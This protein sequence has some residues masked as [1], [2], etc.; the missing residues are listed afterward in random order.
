MCFNVINRFHFVQNV[1]PR[2]ICVLDEASKRWNSTA[3]G[4]SFSSRL[5]E[6]KLLHALNFHSKNK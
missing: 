4:P 2:V 6:E 3:L 5:L 1:K